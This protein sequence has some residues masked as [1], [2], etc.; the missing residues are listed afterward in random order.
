[1][2]TT[3]RAA[4]ITVLL[5]GGVVIAASGPANAHALLRSSAP[6]DGA[7]LSRAP[8]KIVLDFTETPEPEVSSVQVLDPTGARVPSSKPTTVAGKPSA[9]QISVGNLPTG[10]YT[11]TWRAVSKVDGH[12]TAGS[13]AFGIGRSPHATSPRSTSQAPT[14]PSPAPLS[15]AGRWMLYWGLSLILAAAV[16]TRLVFKRT[17]VLTRP[18]LSLAWLLALAGIALMVV[19]A[20]STIGVGLGQLLRSSTGG[21]L[22]EQALGVALSG[23]GVLIVFL[24]RESAG[25]L[26]AG[27]G[28]LVGMWFHAVGSH[29]SLHM[30]WFN[31]PVQFVHIAAVGI[32]VGGLVWLIVTL[33]GA[34]G[35]ERAS[36]VRRFSWLFGLTLCVV[37]VTGTLR[38][39]DEVGGIGK[40][41][42]AVS[43]S[44]GITLL[45]KIGLFLVLVALGALNRYINIPA[46]ESNGPRSKGLNRTVAL[47]IAVAALILATTGVLSQSP[48]PV[49]IAGA[50]TIATS[51]SDVV[52]SGH[53]FATTARA[54]LTVTPGFPGQ[55]NFSAEVRD[56]D[57]GR[58]VAAR[59]VTLN[60]TLPAR[61][62]VGAST[63]KLSQGAPGTWAGKGTNL[64]LPGRWA[65][66]VTVQEKSTAVEIPLKVQTRTAPQHITTQSVPGQPTVYTISI[67][68][69]GK[70]QTY[71]DPGHPGINNVHFTFFASS[72][73]EEAIASAHVMA[74][75]PQGSHRALKLTR[76]DKGHFVA[77]VHLSAGTWTFATTAKTRS[78]LSVNGHFSQQI[79]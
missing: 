43:T 40:L 20:R 32:W 74:T 17:N 48:P 2:R 50:A 30:T 13:F 3:P 63:L 7:Q 21:N 72:G 1:M 49:D 56:F 9:M 65:I 73:R 42:D 59:A 51:P 34:R 11:V 29:A 18:L 44:F 58:P 52:V 64:S 76:F 37:A 62:D 69:G 36:E 27:A 79:K 77:N 31:V 22:A 41:W 47:E 6:A 23:L 61:A 57:T 46:W 67:A 75:D 35:E 45:I 14:T 10:V 78:G 26:L 16:S 39:L 60:F 15:V 68:T 24:D 66:T 53:D 70:L 12:V 4:I 8:S 54:K 55:N 5:I 19:S 25:Y 38:A 71:I 33:Q 28:A